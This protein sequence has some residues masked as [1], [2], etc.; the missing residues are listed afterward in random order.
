MPAVI[1]ND[2][3]ELRADSLGYQ[4]ARVQ[5]PSQPSNADTMVFY[6]KAWVEGWPVFTT[7]SGTSYSWSPSGFFGLSFSESVSSLPRGIVGWMN[8]NST[9]TGYGITRATYTDWNVPAGLQVSLFTFSNAGT[10]N[11]S[12]YYGSSAT[13]ATIISNTAGY[14]FATN[15]VVGTSAINVVLGVIKLQKV[16][17]N[18]SNISVSFGINWEGLS[19]SNYTTALTSTG[20]KWLINNSSVLERFNFRPNWNNPSLS[21]TIT[22]P[23][24]V[25]A[26]WTSG[27]PGRNLVVDSLRVEYYNGTEL[28]GT[29]G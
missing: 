29:V 15:A 1:S 16:E 13:N 28:V 8:P 21:S 12:F 6:Y 9:V 11:N 23:S 22:F 4:A 27:V 5:L 7:E 26:R 17:A 2:R 24:W 25:V 10:F 18:P 3:L 14:P 19:Q 20:T